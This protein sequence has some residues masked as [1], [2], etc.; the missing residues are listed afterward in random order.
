MIYPEIFSREVGLRQAYKGGG[1]ERQK[2]LGLFLKV[3]CNRCI[4]IKPHR[5]KTAIND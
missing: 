5:V 3:L 1:D 4:S 2:K